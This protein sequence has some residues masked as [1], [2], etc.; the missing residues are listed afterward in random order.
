MFT[1]TAKTYA[2]G[3]DIPGRDVKWV[4]GQSR[5]VH[6][7]CIGYYLNNPSAW[8]VSDDATVRAKTNS[9]GGIV[10]S[11]PGGILPM[12][13]GNTMVVIGDSLSSLCGGPVYSA[14]S[15][16]T[17]FTR[18]ASGTHYY[19]TTDNTYYTSNGS[20]WS[21]TPAGAETDGHTN[22]SFFMHAMQKA[23]KPLR[24]I[25][26]GGY[27]GQKS[28]EILARFDAEVIAKSPAIVSIFAGANDPNAGV[29][30]ADT[31]SN[32]GQ[33]VSKALA[34]KIVVIVGTV[35]PNSVINTTAE[36]QALDTVN[37]YIKSLSIVPGVHVWDGFAAISTG[38][39]TYPG[40]TILYDGTHQAPQGSMLA[41][42]K[43]G[44]TLS[45][46]GFIAQ[47][48]PRFDTNASANLIYN[49]AAYATTGGG[50]VSGTNGFSVSGSLTGVGPDGW[51]CG[52]LGT[53]GSDTIVGSIV[54]PTDGNGGNW[55]AFTAAA[56][57][58][59]TDGHAVY[60]QW[61][62][63]LAAMARSQA[64]Q[65]GASRVYNSNRYVCVANGTTAGSAPT[66][67]ETIGATTADGTATWK[68]VPNVAAGDEIE[69]AYEYELDAAMAAAGVFMAGYVE[70]YV[71]G[72]KILQVGSTYSKTGFPT[73]HPTKG[74]F[75]AP[76][77]KIP[78][79][80]TGIICYSRAYLKAAA[81]GVI[82]LRGASLTDI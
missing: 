31:I 72:S 45:Q 76:P 82:K 42:Y 6:E 47:T 15:A 19:N 22:V 40:A 1:V 60:A 69:F 7:D 27:F 56:V 9:T 66:F 77:V 71:S 28:G 61:N 51:G 53:W 74:V 23:F 21:A 36:L 58:G 79:N 59:S 11:V 63:S 18:F 5:E 62:I 55:A 34:A 35:W 3:Q 75:V 8:E 30:A 13:I 50:D 25:H 70:I 4:P 52:T 12:R 64:Y 43:L 2:T 16:P 67:D 39:N 68:R 24:I 38:S 65:L 73:L 17:D 32:I 78:A 49:G 48:L 10:L 33:M 14:A 54:A 26:N 81:A 80:C 20:A 44:D 29:S 46:M 37:N 57:S 41:G